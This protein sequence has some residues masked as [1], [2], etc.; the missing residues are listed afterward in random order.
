[1]LEMRNVVTDS[2]K[3]DESFGENVIK[4]NDFC[5]FFIPVLALNYRQCVVQSWWWQPCWPATT[6]THWSDLDLFPSLLAA[7]GL[8]VLQL[9]HLLGGGVQ[10]LCGPA[11]PEERPL[12]G[13]GDGT[14]HGAERR[15]ATAVLADQLPPGCVR[16]LPPS[17]LCGPRARRRP[18][19]RPE[20]QH[21]VRLQTPPHHFPMPLLSLTL[22]PVLLACGRYSIDPQSD[23]EAVFRIA[24]DTGSISTVM[25]LDREE[26]Q[27]HNI[28]VM[29]TQR[30]A[31]QPR[32][33]PRAPPWRR[34]AVMGVQ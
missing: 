27:W 5:E 25:E 6:K 8:R 4:C 21:Q 3:L 29:A 13:P 9:L 19:Y 30:G 16:E 10:P 33:S 1:M 32:Q 28:T 2:A 14:G 11:L 20:Q 22:T 17:L 24:S 23:P 15:R 18:R 12:Q 31:S 26:E 7:A 34:S